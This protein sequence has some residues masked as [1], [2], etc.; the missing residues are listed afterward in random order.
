MLQVLLL[1]HDID[2]LLWQ[3]YR[4]CIPHKRQ[5]EEWEQ[6]VEYNQKPLQIY[7]DLLQQGTKPRFV[8]RKIPDQ[9]EGARVEAVEG[10]PTTLLEGM[11]GNFG[12]A[13]QVAHGLEGRTTIA[14]TLMPA[15][16]YAS[17]IPA[18]TTIPIR[19]DVH[20][21]DNVTAISRWQL[22]AMS[23]SSENFSWQH[24]LPRSPVNIFVT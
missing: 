11:Q 3:N 8:L 17:P 15:K 24:Q 16:A 18:R 10:E 23:R 19:K 1:M 14:A 7:A 13:K 21:Q 2:I 9:T 22:P 6:T 4:V 5:S 12:A 20:A